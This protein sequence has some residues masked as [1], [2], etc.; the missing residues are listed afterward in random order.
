MTTWLSWLGTDRDFSFK[1]EVSLGKP[2]RVVHPLRNLV[3][4][5]L[6]SRRWGGRGRVVLVFVWFTH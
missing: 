5:G 6:W 3:N 2:G 4:Y 1:I